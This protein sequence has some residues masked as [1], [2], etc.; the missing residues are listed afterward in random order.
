MVALTIAAVF[1]TGCGTSP[2]QQQGSIWQMSQTDFE[3]D[4]TLQRE[5]MA[6]LD[7]I[8]RLLEQQG[9]K[10]LDEAAA[11]VV[12]TPVSE[13]EEYDLTADKPNWGYQTV[14]LT[15]AAPDDLRT[16][17]DEQF[18]KLTQLIKD[19][20]CNCDQP[21]MS[22]QA[23]AT[24][25]P[26]L[27]EPPEVVTSDRIVSSRIVSVGQPVITYGSPVS[28]N[29]PISY[30]SGTTGYSSGSDGVTFSCQNGVCRQV[31]RPSGYSRRT[32]RI[33]R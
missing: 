14:S 21:V 3:T 23:P 32:V 17:L 15:T 22:A 7:R 25:T 8:E 13:P 19:S 4:A 12:S 10:A 31:Q 28:Y 16:Y 26:T 18:E 30:Q 20:A 33:R 24:Q 29:A 27:F 5:Q 11:I 2:Q 1:F 6:K 9:D